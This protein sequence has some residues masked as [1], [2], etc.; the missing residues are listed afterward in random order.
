MRNRAEVEFLSHIYSYKPLILMF[1]YNI[2]FGVQFS[3]SGDGDDDDDDNNKPF[4]FVS[5][6]NNSSNSDVKKPFHF[7]TKL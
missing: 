5:R 4:F 6:Y 2:E 3:N 7:C 1:A